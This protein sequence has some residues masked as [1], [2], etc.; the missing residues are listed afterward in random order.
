MVFMVLEHTEKAVGRLR[1]RDGAEVYFRG[2]GKKRA[3]KKGAGEMEV[4]GMTKGEHAS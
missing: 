3:R 4:E 1:A 2:A